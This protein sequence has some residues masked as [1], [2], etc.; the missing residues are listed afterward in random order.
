MYAADREE[1]MKRILCVLACLMACVSIQVQALEAPAKLFYAADYASVLSD[2]TEMF[3]VEHSA[4]LAESTGAQIVVAT[5]EDLEGRD[6]MD[7]GLD[8]LRT[9]KVGSEKNNGVV[10]LVSTGD[11][12]IGINVGYGL[13]G[14]LND[15]KVGRLIDT[16][17]VPSLKENDYDTGIFQLYNAVL[18][19]VYNEYG[20][21]VPENV[22]SLDDYKDKEENDAEPFI[23]LGVL[24]VLVVLSV[25]NRRNGPPPPNGPGGHYRRRGFYGGYFGG[26]PYG[27]SGGFGGGG[28]GGFGGGGG[29]GGGGGASRGF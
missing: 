13:E 9:W 25:F 12:K 18:A 14:A 27:G 16:C 26:P 20:M 7:Y 10:I 17:A 5:V 23:I 28:F 11:R 8:L 3:V 21:D 22:K 24:G 4:A 29:S 6:V 1:R 15:A 2:E 19:E